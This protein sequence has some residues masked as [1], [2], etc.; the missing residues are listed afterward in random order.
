MVI[1][2]GLLL[3]AL[4]ARADG[5][6]WEPRGGAADLYDQGAKALAAGDPAGAER[7]F[8]AALGKQPGCGMALHGLGYA[9]L[10][11]DRRAEALRALDQARGAFPDQPDLATAQSEARFA[12]QD[13][14]GAR[15][16]ARDAVRLD[17]QSLDAW[18]ALEAALTRTGAY[19]EAGESL[20]DAQLYLPVEELACLEVQLRLELDDTA[21][22]TELMRACQGSS[23]ED[24]VSATEALLAQ[25]TGSTTE[26]GEIMGALGADTVALVVKAA[27]LYNGG[28]PEPALTV[29]DA[30]LA[31][32][33]ERLDARVM[34]GQVRYALDDRDGARSDLEAAFAGETWVEVHASG[35]MSGILR[36][37]DEEKL[38]RLISDGAGVLIR[39][40]T[41]DGELE[42]ARAVLAKTQ[43][44]PTPGLRA[45]TAFLRFTEGDVAGA[46][47]ELS[48]GMAADGPDARLLDMAGLLAWRDL[49][50][51]DPA[52]LAAIRAQGPPSAVYNLAS[53][54]ANAGRSA[55]CLATLRPAD[56]GAPFDERVSVATLSW[57]CAVQS[58]SLLDADARLAALRDLDPVDPLPFAAGFN[59]ALLLQRAD[60]LADARALAAGLSADDQ[61]STARRD[62][63]LMVLDADLARIDDALRLARDPAR[64]PADVAW[65]GWRLAE[66]GRGADAAPLLKG[67]CPRLEGDMKDQCDAVLASVTE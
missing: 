8:R 44:A 9:L 56:A 50:A 6:A 12:A 7:A 4:A 39:L 27:D 48:K 24:L 64:D 65:V 31:R 14:P 37:S 43:G 60:R 15:A 42:A 30:V 1:A 32:T 13:F 51:A 11:Q 21:A 59:H 49:A 61:G 55:D 17:P 35:M 52:F 47:E 38:R 62:G 46:W 3:V 36:K 66:A 29:L 23:R 2:A 63:L 26:A 41:E 57:R 10:F 18:M 22:A 20:D 33:P 40:L 19:D 28:Q 25:A 5:P 34:R 53:A 45:G 54:Y 67:A 58:E 16:S